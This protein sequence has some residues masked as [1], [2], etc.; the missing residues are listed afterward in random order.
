MGQSGVEL[1]LKNNKFTKLVNT[2]YEVGEHHLQTLC[3]AIEFPNIK[4]PRLNTWTMLEHRTPLSRSLL[5][6]ADVRRTTQSSL[7]NLIA[8]LAST[9]EGMRGRIPLNCTSRWYRHSFIREDGFGCIGCIKGGL[10][11]WHSRFALD[12]IMNSSL[13]NQGL[14]KKLMY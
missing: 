11:V 7:H 2:I 14:V 8:C 10:K 13:L 5:R 4:T 9:G 3:L 6:C 12:D 1:I